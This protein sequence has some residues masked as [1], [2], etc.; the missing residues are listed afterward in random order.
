MK[1]KLLHA[2]EACRIRRNWLSGAASATDPESQQPR[3]GGA[4]HRRTA[5]RLER[6]PQAVQPKNWGPGRDDLA[7][8]R[9]GP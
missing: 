8:H 4:G 1:Q 6:R 2:G 3:L 7:R 5:R 9:E